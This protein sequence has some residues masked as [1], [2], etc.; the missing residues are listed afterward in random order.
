MQSIFPMT[1]ER[2]HDGLGFLLGGQL[3]PNLTQLQLL[4]PYFTHMRISHYVSLSY[5]TMNSN[6][7]LILTFI[8]PTLLFFIHV[9]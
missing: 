1:N 9:K 2:A 8:S 6:R 7:P 5:F 4:A 3:R